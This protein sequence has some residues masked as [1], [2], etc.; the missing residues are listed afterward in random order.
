MVNFLHISDLHISHG[1]GDEGNKN[2]N[3]QELLKAII[4]VANSLKPEPKFIIC[5]GDLTD[6]G[7]LESYE[8]FKSVISQSKFPILL[9][10]GNH[11]NRSNFRKVFYNRPSNYPLFYNS[12]HGDVRVVVLD[13][14]QPG[15]ISGTI[16]EDQFR[17]LE[18][19][20]LYYKYQ[21]QT[22]IQ[23]KLF[24]MVDLRP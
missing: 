14:S 13:T 4:G 21:D 7:D 17:F 24:L 5:S 8:D 1:F 3:T 15:K 9:A 23:L 12:E 2:Y 10:L 11:D 22:W 20:E 16:C 19:R 18:E 6:K